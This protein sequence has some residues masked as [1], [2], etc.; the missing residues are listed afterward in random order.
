M[1]KDGTRM[2][3][4]RGCSKAKMREKNGDECEK[5]NYWKGLVREN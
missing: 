4:W 2:R 3:S 1:A 5:K